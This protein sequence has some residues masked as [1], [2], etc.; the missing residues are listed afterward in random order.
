MSDS[1]EPR[2]GTD[3]PM[4]AAASLFDLRTVIAVLFGVYGLV[5]LIIGLVS[6]GPSDL[7]KTGGAN[8]NLETGIAMLVVAALFVIWVVARPV[9]PPTPTEPDQMGP[10]AEPDRT[11]PE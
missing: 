5:L 9:R 1:T 6:T 4:S 7:V 11:W 3:T 8:I 10:S 2:A